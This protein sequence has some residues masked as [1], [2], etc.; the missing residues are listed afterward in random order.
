MAISDNL[1]TQNP[2]WMAAIVDRGLRMLERDKNQ[3][4]VIIWSLGNES[5]YGPGQPPLPHPF[6][7]NAK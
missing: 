6:P 7:T 3:P 4:S 2:L 1:Q 5:G